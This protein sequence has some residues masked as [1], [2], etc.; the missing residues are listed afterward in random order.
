[1]R[2]TLDATKAKYD[3]GEETRTSIAQAEAS[4][5]QGT[6]EREAAEAG[7][8]SAEA[9]FER[10]T[11]ARPGKLKKPGEPSSL[12]RG[13]KEAIEIAK[14]NNPAILAALYQEKADRSAI[15]VSD[16]D[17]LPKVDLNGSVARTGALTRYK[18]ATGPTQTNDFTTAQKVSVNL[19][20]PIYEGGAF[21][22]RSRELREVAEQSR[23]KIETKRREIIQDLVTAWETYLAAK[24]NVVSYRTQVKADEV[25]LEGTRQE[26]LVGSK[27]LLDVLNAQRELVSAQLRLVQAEQTYYENAYKVLAIMGRLTAMDMKLKVKRYDPQVHYQDVRDSW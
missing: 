4:L 24:A 6:A 3:V 2:A 19:K 18:F 5:A 21:R 1:L 27:I 26:M 11:G 20:V 10:V 12:P 7:L 25:S 15:K 9:T 16:A 17:L 13:L 14:K 22:G 8:L 23:I